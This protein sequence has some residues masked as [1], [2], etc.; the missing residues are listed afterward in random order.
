MS[1][2]WHAPERGSQ[3]RGLRTPTCESGFRNLRVERQSGFF[4]FIAF[5]PRDK[6]VIIIRSAYGT[7]RERMCIA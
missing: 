7:R 2:G 1:G 5:N 6:R 3:K 4:L